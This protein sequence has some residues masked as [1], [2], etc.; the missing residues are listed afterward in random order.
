MLQVQVPLYVVNTGNVK[1]FYV[2]GALL[3]VCVGAIM[4][5]RSSIPNDLRGR[6]NEEIR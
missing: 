3:N 5:T 2:I 6:K 4:R 1:K